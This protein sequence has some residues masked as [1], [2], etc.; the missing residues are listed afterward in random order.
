MLLLIMRDSRL[1]F[2]QSTLEHLCWKHMQ[3][4]TSDPT[5]VMKRRWSI[6]FSFFL[7]HKAAWTWK[8]LWLFS[9]RLSIQSRRL[10]CSSFVVFYCF[11]WAIPIVSCSVSLPL[12]V[13]TKWSKLSNANPTPSSES[14][15]LFQFLPL[16]CSWLS[17]QDYWVLQSLF[18]CQS[19]FS[20]LNQ[21]V[22]I[23][24]ESLLHW[25]HRKWC[26][27]QMTSSVCFFE[28]DCFLRSGP[29]MK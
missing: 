14:I 3:S 8:H 12:N 1:A 7:L 27:S 11:W 19:D 25:K 6:Q 10:E 23:L 13:S 29:L 22:N 20:L 2:L 18:Y 15:V 28:D 17:G 24:Q 26:S 21:L 9:V 5:I 4:F 16:H